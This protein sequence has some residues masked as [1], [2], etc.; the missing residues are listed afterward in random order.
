LLKK[1]KK[2]KKAYECPEGKYCRTAQI[3]PFNCDGLSFFDFYNK[4]K[5]NKLKNIGIKYLFIYSRG[6]SVMVRVP[7]N[8][9][10]YFQQ[11]MNL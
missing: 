6:E 10:N 5:Q 3:Q 8:K 4:T 2:N 11:L 7:K 9:S 1:I